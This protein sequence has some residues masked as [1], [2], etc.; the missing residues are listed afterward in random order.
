MKKILLMVALIVASCTEDENPTP[1]KY[2]VIV[3]REQETYIYVNREL[4]Q[5]QHFYMNIKLSIKK[6]Y[7]K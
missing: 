5:I 3:R 7:I 4:D 6:K 1:A 2:D